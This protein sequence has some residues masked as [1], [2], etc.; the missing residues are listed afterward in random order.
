[1]SS[2][3]TSAVRPK[4]V[5]S[6]STA[7]PLHT[8]EAHAIHAR[9]MD[10]H[11][12]DVPMHYVPGNPIAAHVYNCMHLLLPQGEKAM[13]RAMAQALPLVDDPRLREEMIGFIGQEATHADQHGGM[14]GRLVELGLDPQPVID[15]MDRIIDLIMSDTGSERIRH[16]LLCERL[17][18][19]SALEH[20]TAVWGKFFLESE[21]L[22]NSGIHPMILDLLKWHGAEEVEHRSVVFDAYMYVDGS[23]ARRARMAVL[24]S[25][26][27][28]VTGITTLTWLAAHDPELNQS[29]APLGWMPGLVTDM[30]RA[31]RR[32][33]IPNIAGFVTEIPVY[34]R[35]GFHPS[36]L[37]GMEAAVRYLATAPIKDGR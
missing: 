21:G 7:S 17:A 5:N 23:Y 18:L 32:R 29:H 33:V 15:R 13:S 30:V 1:M 20:Y 6:P 2:P 31:T 11:W 16:Q 22:E 9:D 8:S 37:P 28:A 12:D 4:T 26:A 34:L 10:F 14:M 19:F 36:Q 24:G 35:P 25:L 27:L 3:A